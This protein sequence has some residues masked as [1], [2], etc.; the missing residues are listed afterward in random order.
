MARA[1]SLVHEARGHRSSWRS[2]HVPPFDRS[3]TF[4]ELEFT[5]FAVLASFPQIIYSRTSPRPTSYHPTLFQPLT[6]RTFLLVPRLTD[7]CWL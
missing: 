6:P 2:D 1:L 7:Y 5:C 4:P 3:V